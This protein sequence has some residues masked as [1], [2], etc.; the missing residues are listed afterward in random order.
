MANLLYV[1][2]LRI[3]RVLLLAAALV[4]GTAVPANA[5]FCFDDCI[6]EY[7]LTVDAGGNTFWYTG[8]REFDRGGGSVGITCYYTRFVWN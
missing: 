1:S 3:R 2:R 7:G 6:N 8:C 4:L 5:Y